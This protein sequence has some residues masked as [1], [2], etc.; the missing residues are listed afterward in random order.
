MA[1]SLRDPSL[2]IGRSWGARG[3]TWGTCL[4]RTGCWIVQGLQGEQA[5]GGSWAPRDRSGAGAPARFL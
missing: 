3:C 2:C 1:H 4:L 5:S